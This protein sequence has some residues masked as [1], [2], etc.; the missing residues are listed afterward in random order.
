[1]DDKS[2]SS[3]SE[4]ERVLLETGRYSPARLLL[5]LVADVLATDEFTVELE[6]GS[7]AITVTALQ[8]TVALDAIFVTP[9]TTIPTGGFIPQRIVC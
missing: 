3:L 7:F 6:A 5:L 9:L 2:V 8:G 1:M 4:P